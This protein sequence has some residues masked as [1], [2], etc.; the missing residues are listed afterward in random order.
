[1]L[2]HPKFKT[3]FQEMSHHQLV[4]DEIDFVLTV[5]GSVGFEYAALGKT[6]INASMCNPH[7]AYNFNIHPESV[8]EYKSI[9]MNLAEMDKVIDEAEVYEYYYMRNLNEAKHNWLDESYI[10]RWSDF[11]GNEESQTIGTAVKSSSAC[12][13]GTLM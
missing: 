12:L 2:K 4:R 9:L 3:I 8:E 6:V 13:S 5:Y 7:V 11:A 1:M 10:T